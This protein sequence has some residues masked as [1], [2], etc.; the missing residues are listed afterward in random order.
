MDRRFQSEAFLLPPSA[1]REVITAMHR[2]GAGAAGVAAFRAGFVLLEQGRVAVIKILQLHPRNFLFDE[3]FDGEDVIGILH[4][5]QR[6]H[7]PRGFRPAR[8]ADGQG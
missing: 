2:H 3:A 6:E 7:I 4:D 1:G 5:H 8:T